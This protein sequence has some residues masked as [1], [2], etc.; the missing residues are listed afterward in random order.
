MIADSRPN[1]Q[2]RNI[3]IQ[4]LGRAPWWL[5]IA[6]LLIVGFFLAVSED[7][8][9]QNLIPLVVNSVW[10]TIWVTV[11][12]YALS[13]VL[14][15]MIALLRLS[16]NV[17]VYQSVTLYVEI[18][19]G[20]PTLVLVYWV[21]LAFVPLLIDLINQFGIN[22]LGESGFT[23]LRARDVNGELRAIIALAIS[24][25]AFLSEVFRAGIESVGV[26]QREAGLSLGMTEG[27]V[28]RRIILPQAIRNILPPLANDF[29]AMLKESSLVS[30]VG[31]ND[32]TRA[33]STYA[34]ATFTFFQSYNV[35]AITYL[36]LTLSLS[37]GVKALEWWMSRGK[38]RDS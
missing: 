20:I 34:Y 13:L 12:A 17:I 15:L 38:G 29:I 32:I 24:Y 36:I 14:G 6:A 35:V 21:V 19:R 1:P 10:T 22:L 31:V 9:Y 7:R 16:K 11:V 2:K 25:S 28:M 26:G 18:V 4:R 30:I 33:G 3:L 5:L 23:P 27:Q 8:I 37:M